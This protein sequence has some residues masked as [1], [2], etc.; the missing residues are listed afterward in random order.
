MAFIKVNKQSRISNR[1]IKKDK[2]KL[3]HT[4]SRISLL[5]HDGDGEA[6]AEC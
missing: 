3:Y 1:G 4:T 2:Y 6:K 5:L